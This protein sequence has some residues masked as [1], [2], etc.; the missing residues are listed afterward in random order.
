M[1]S[2]TSR[3]IQLTPYLLVEYRYTSPIS[4]ERFSYNISRI[5]N[6]HTSNVQILNQ[7]SA[8]DDTN[9]VQERSAVQI[10]PGKFVDLDKDQ[11]PTYLTY[12]VDLSATNISAAN[13]PYDTIRYHIVAGYTFEDLDGVIMQVQARERSGKTSRY[14]SSY[15]LRTRISSRSTQSQSFLA[16]DCMTVTWKSRCRP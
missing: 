9:N 1:A 14:P 7:D 10:S 3:F 8:V 11:V 15:S 2:Y 4:P 16:S 5:S 6:G 12:D 13:A